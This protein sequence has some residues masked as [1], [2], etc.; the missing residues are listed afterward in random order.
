MPRIKSRGGRPHPK[1]YFG[2]ASEAAEAVSATE[3]DVQLSDKRSINPAYKPDP[4][5]TF[6][7]RN[8]P[9]K[10]R[11][12][13]LAD[14]GPNLSNIAAKFA[15]KKEGQ[16]WLTNWILSPERYHPK[17]LMPNLQLAEQDAADIASWLLSVAGEWPVTVEVLPLEIVAEI[18]WPVGRVGDRAAR[19]AVGAGRVAG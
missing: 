6:D 1:I 18:A 8:F 12:N 5:A 11:E 14:F 2:G 3:A 19:R 17:S 4:A 16:K 15:G 7:P 13:A 9:E 10:V